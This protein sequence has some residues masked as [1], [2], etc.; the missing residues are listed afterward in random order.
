MPKENKNLSLKK[1]G[2]VFKHGGLE[3]TVVCTFEDD[4]EQ[5]FVAKHKIRRA[6]TLSYSNVFSYFKEDGK[7]YK[8]S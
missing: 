1:V 2:D 5:F 8:R 3:Y 7:I 6:N 4:G